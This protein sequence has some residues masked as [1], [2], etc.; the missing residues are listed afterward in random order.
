MGEHFGWQTLPAAH[1][2][3]GVESRRYDAGEWT[4]IHY[5]FAPGAVFPLH[6]HPEG[7]TVVVLRG[8]LR[9]RQ[10]AEPGWVLQAGEGWTVGPGEPH[11]MAAGPEGAEFLNCIA[12]RRQLDRNESLESWEEACRYAAAPPPAP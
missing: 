1:P 9:A 7:Q 11:G 6:R 5:R 8:W 2:F 4:L 10:G 3:P 12:P